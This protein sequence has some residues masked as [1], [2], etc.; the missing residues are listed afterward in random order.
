MNVK[1]LFFEG[2]GFCVFSLDLRHDVVTV[3]SW[4]DLHKCIIRR[5]G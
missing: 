2:N 3:D 5:S 1:H 4:V